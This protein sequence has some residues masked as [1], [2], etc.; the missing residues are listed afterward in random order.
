M[1]LDLLA[2]AG[3]TTLYLAPWFL[4]N[5]LDEQRA[6]PRPLTALRWVITGSSPVSP[7][8]IEEV[9][10]VFGL[11]LFALW[12]MSENGPVTVTRLEDPPLVRRRDCSPISDM[13]LRIKPPWQAPGEGF[14]GPRPSPGVGY[15]RREE[16]HGE[17]TAR[18]PSTGAREAERPRR[19][20]FSCGLRHDLPAGTVLHPSGQRPSRVI[21]RPPCATS[22]L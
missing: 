8:L 19:H 6:R 21:R 7:H 18:P 9:R 5:L 10:D 3:V 12:G 1:G 2:V 4:R 17:Q 16:L 20:R 11:R 22:D 15:Y 13:E 14:C